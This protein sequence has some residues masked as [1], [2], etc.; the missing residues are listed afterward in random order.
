[1]NDKNFKNLCLKVFLF[2][3]KFF[4]FFILYKRRLVWFINK[5]NNTVCKQNL[6]SITKNCFSF[7]KTLKSSAEDND[8]ITNYDGQIKDKNI[9]IKRMFTNV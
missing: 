3:V 2:L 9:Y 5:I 7:I 4:F 8:M 6:L 1:M